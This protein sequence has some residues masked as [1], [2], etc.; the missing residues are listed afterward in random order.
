MEFLLLASFEP[1]CKLTRTFSILD[2][3]F[4][5]LEE[6]GGDDCLWFGQIF[7]GTRCNSKHP[8]WRINGARAAAVRVPRLPG[9]P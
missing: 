7:G 9:H 2:N 6:N 4:C 1:S 8:R 5:F 3:S